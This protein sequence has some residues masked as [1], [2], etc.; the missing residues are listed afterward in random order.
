MASS[1][2]FKSYDKL[3][4]KS[5]YHAWKM[6]LDLTLEEQDVMDYVQGKITESPS[7]AP[8]AAK[9]KY[10]K[11]EVK[12]KK[13]IVDSI[14]KPLVALFLIWKHLRRCMTKWLGCSQQ[15]MQSSPLAEEQ[16]ERHQD[17]QRRIH[18]ILLHE[19]YQDQE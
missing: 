19:D 7:N 5:D 8:A 6:S 9:T 18:S 15:I 12:S 4:D 10:K 13:I 16:V 14:H 11:G 2:Y 17:G 3:N 1:S